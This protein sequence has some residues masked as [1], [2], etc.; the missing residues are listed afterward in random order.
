MNDLEK[1]ILQALLNNEPLQKA[2]RKV[3]AITIADNEP[4]IGEGNNTLLGE[5]FRAYKQAEEIINQGF[6]SLMSYK[7]ESKKT[8]GF[9][10]GV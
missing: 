9:N 6:I 2:L 10:K 4:K 7:R 5:K 8:Q 3:F 1:D